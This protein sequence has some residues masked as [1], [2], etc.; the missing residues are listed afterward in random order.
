MRF[1]VRRWLQAPSWQWNALIMATFAVAV[2]IYGSWQLQQNQSSFRHHAINQVRLIAGILERNAQQSATAQQLYQNVI[3]AFLTSTADFLLY[4]DRV[5]PFRS[6]ELAAFAWENNLSLVGIE[7]R[8]DSAARYPEN[9]P[10]AAQASHQPGLHYLP[11]AHLYLLRKHSEQRTLTLAIPAHQLEELQQQLSQQQLLALMAEL[12]GIAYATTEDA[13]AT[14]DAK[15][16]EQIDIRIHDDRSPAVAEARLRWGDQQLLVFGLE[17]TQYEKRRQALYRELG[18]L[19]SIMLLMG[20]LLSWLLFHQQRRMVLHA[21]DLE[22][23]LARQHE[24]A[25]LGRAADSISH[26]I[27][28]PLNAVSM[29]LQRLEMEATDLESEHRAL[30]GAMRQALTRTTTTISQLQHFARPLRPDIRTLNLDDLI[31]GLIR[32]YQP[33]ADDRRIDINPQIPEGIT[34]DADPQMLCQALENLLKNAIDA[35]PDGG[36]ITLEVHDDNAGE[37]VIDIVN[38]TADNFDRN[39]LARL[40]EPYVTYKTRGTGLG[41][42]LVRKIIQAHNGHLELSQPRPRTFRAR[43]LMPAPRLTDEL[44]EPAG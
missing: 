42:P 25:A 18:G 15:T 12:P 10:E 11:D 17:A 19:I 1:V 43:L 24:E 23:Q 29:G 32:L 20:G 4:L 44:L 38:A 28:N 8:D 9:W 13:P 40:A 31:C 2:I 16:P 39:E 7:R 21:K 5:E 30:I 35:Q 37:I 41:L 14:R 3:G 27:R 22:R 6:E 33:Q 36:W 26:E 34:L